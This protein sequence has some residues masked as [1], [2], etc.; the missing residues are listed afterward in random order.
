VDLTTGTRY[1]LS[2][3]LGNES[4]IDLYWAADSTSSAG[5]W[6][7]PYEAWYQGF[8]TA[9]TGPNAWNAALISDVSFAVVYVNFD[10]VSAYSTLEAL[11]AEHDILGDW[12]PD[13]SAAAANQALLV[14]VGNDNGG[15]TPALYLV[16]ETNWTNGY[17]GQVQVKSRSAR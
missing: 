16:D 2:A 3:S 10:T 1:T 5:Y 17:T 13:R 8:G 7:T 12:I 15:A 4:K 6:Y 14:W 9:T 11:E